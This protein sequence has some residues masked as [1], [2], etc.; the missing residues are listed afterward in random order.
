MTGAGAGVVTA[1]V[2]DELPLEEPLPEDDD[3]EVPWLPAEAAF[4]PSAGSDPIAI[5]T[6]RTAQI[7]RKAA[8]EASAIRIVMAV[9]VSR[10][11][12][13]A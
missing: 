13:D 12:A 7:A 9:V 8:A 2:L 4:G 5:W 10:E 11:R 3:V 6:E 1:A